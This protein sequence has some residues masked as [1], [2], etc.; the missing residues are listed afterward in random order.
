MIHKH[1]WGLLPGSSAL[2]R[3][4]LHVGWEKLE[5]PDSVC[6]LYCPA[7]LSLEISLDSQLPAHWQM[8]KQD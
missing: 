7:E 3:P 6:I 4:L 5:D 8:Y 2:A 1:G